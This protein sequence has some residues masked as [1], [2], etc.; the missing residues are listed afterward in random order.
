MNSREIL[1]EGASQLGFTLGEEQIQKLLTY[2]DLL[3]E[4]N[5]KVNLTSITDEK[6]IMIKHFLDSL[7]CVI[8]PYIKNRDKV[9]DVGTGAGFPGIPIHIYYP[10]IHLTLLDSLQKRIA[11]LEEVYKNIGIDNI[12]FQH[13]RAEDFGA[14]PKFREKYDVALARAVAQLSVLCEYCLPFVKMGGYFLCQKGPNV[15]EE[16]INA[17]NAIE[18]LGGQFIE[19]IDI[20]LPFSDINHNII[21]IKKIRQTPAK[22]PRKAGTPTKSP[23][24]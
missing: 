23:I 6:E 19:K 21:I 3:S 16:L 4:W 5:E 13:G 9:I 20:K 12:I 10:E 1:R 24:L 14:N 18:L 17:K 2:K 11:F 15:D 22:Y 7:T 8:K